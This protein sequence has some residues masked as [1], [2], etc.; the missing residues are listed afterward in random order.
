M[1]DLFI[2]RGIEI[3]FPGEK[4]ISGKDMSWDGS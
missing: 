4:G 1:A 3:Y 2:F